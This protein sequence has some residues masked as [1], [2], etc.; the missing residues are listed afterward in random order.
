MSANIEFASPELTAF[1]RPQAP[2]IIPEHPLLIFLCS[3]IRA[4][5]RRNSRASDS[6]CDFFTRWPWTDFRNAPGRLNLWMS[7]HGSVISTL[8]ALGCDFSCTGTR[9]ARAMSNRPDLCT[10]WSDKL[11][12]AWVSTQ[13]WRIF[14]LS[15]TEYWR[16][17]SADR[18]SN[19]VVLLVGQ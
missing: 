17:L 13:L 9:F 19:D 2:V 6:A 16:K 18:E 1:A 7:I 14:S 4:A 11:P 3:S 10:L 5:V 12:R 15:L 8:Q